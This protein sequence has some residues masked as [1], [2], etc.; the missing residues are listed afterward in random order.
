MKF[1]D[2]EVG[3]FI[4]REE[5]WNILQVAWPWEL[6]QQL[7]KKN[8]NAENKAV[9]LRANMNLCSELQVHQLGM[10][11]DKDMSASINH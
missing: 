7:C 9:H 1:D 8:N 11:E 2:S 6:E 3:S 5:D 4:A 10:A